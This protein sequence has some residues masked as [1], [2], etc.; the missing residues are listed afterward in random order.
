MPN[1]KAS[2]KPRKISPAIAERR[3]LKLRHAAGKREDS[4]LQLKQSKIH[5]YG[6]Y[7]R[8][9]I[10]KGKVVT[11]YTGT[12]LTIPDADEIYE[13]AR[14]TYLFGLTDCKHVIDGDSEA[15]FINHSCDPNCETDVVR[16]RVIISAIQNIAAGEELTYDYN[17]YDGELN[18]HSLCH[19][20]AKSCRGS[21]YSEK[22]IAKR[23]RL[24]KKLK[25]GN[26]PAEV[27]SRK[28]SKKKKK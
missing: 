27:G 9:P 4:P 23:A 22:E 1:K 13:K 14:R 20:G 28:G 19:C 11:R 24:A 26:Q 3:K 7:T 25:K 18:D 6:C 8:V 21:M 12:K 16:G 15:A 2:L 17:L 10:K 5:S